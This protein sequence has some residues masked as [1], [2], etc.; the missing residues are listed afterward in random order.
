MQ[1]NYPKGGHW[2]GFK[3][4]GNYVKIKHLGPFSG[5]TNAITHIAFWNGWE[6]Q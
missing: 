6:Y 2:I 5:E 3:I 1:T 4:S